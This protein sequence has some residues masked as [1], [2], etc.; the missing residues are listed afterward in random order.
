M[1]A[2]YYKPIRNRHW[3]SPGRYHNTLPNSPLLSAAR[4][5]PCQQIMVT[6]FAASLTHE[7]QSAANGSSTTVSRSDIRLI[8]TF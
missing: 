8:L 4:L 2:L 6:R 1:E 3:L 7:Q 5:S